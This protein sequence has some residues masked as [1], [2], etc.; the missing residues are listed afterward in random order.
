MPYTTEV[1][2]WVQIIA[3]VASHLGGF[4]IFLQPLQ[5]L[6]YVIDYLPVIRRRHHGQV[7]SVLRIGVSERG[8]LQFG[9]VAFELAALLY[10]QVL[11]G[12]LQQSPN[13]LLESG[14]ARTTVGCLSPAV[15]HDLI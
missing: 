8:P 14:E 6:T 5:L 15:E 2:V 11:V 10:V 12:R 4:R 1:Q 13:L 9:N 7:I 3:K